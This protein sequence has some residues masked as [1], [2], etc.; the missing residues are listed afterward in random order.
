[1]ASGSI[2]LSSSKAWEGRIS[3]NSSPN[4]EGNYSDVYFYAGMWKTDGYKT[5]SNSPTNGTITINGTSY[6]LI[7]YQ[8]FRDEVCIYEDTIRIYHNGDGSKSISIS[9]TCNGQSGTSLSGYTLTGSGT[10]ILDTIARASTLDASNGTLG[11]AQTLTINAASDS[12][13]HTIT[14]SCGGSSGT[15][16]E[17]TTA[18]S[19]KW[20]PPMALAKENTT[21][22][23]V[24]VTL[25]IT[26]YSGD[27]SVGSKSTTIT[28]SIPASVKPSCTIAVTDPTGFLDTYGDYIKGQ[29]KFSVVV[30]PT[31]SYGSPIASYSV[32]ANGQKYTSAS[33]ETDVLRE[34]GLLTISATVTDK[35]GRSSITEVTIEVIDCPKPVIEKLSVNRCDKDGTENINGEYIK[36]TFS[37]KVTNLDGQNTAVYTVGYRPTKGSTYTEITLSNLTD[38]FTVTDAEYIFRAD[39]GSSYEVAVYAQDNFTTVQRKTSASTAYVIMHFKANG[40]GLGIGKVAE[41]DGLDVGMVAMFR[42][43]LKTISCPMTSIEEDTVQNW[44]KMN[45]N[46]F[47]INTAGIIT[48]QP[49]TYGFLLNF[50]AFSD[51]FQIWH[52][53]KNGGLYIRSGNSSGWAGTW[54]Q[55]GTN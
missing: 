23:S 14:Y 44:V 32:T 27:T 46:V 15:I 19:V 35:R 43:G 7:K 41:N 20:T 25:K 52:T 12:F 45:N 24:Q 8:E 40:A 10:A 3:W 11:T 49:S 53:Q 21:G 34:S 38:V 6:S 28:C 42:Q 48:D 36:V 54:T 39:T 16:A 30:T 2:S 26:T 1:M 13:T 33:F 17:K 55:I 9:L 29:S 4:I 37:A 51:V 22:T 31:T 50:V 47:W 18:A 5:S